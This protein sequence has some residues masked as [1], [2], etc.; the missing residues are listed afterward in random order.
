MMHTAS[1]IVPVGTARMRS[2]LVRRV[3]DALETF[4][5]KGEF[6][7]LQLGKLRV[8]RMTHRVLWHHDRVYRF[9]LD[10]DAGAVMFPAILPATLP[11]QLLRELRLFLRVDAGID[12]DR[13]E[14]RVFM[15]HGALTLSV[16]VR[17]DAYEYCIDRLVRVADRV[18]GPFLE[19]PTYVEYRKHSLARTAAVLE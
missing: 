11:P 18:L 16:T 6:R 9:V 10:V 5:R 1:T 19:Q 15:Q 3:T 4:D 17:R 13:G 12:P 2:S 14:L 7:Q 8:G